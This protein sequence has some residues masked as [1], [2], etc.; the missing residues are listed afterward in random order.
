MSAGGGC[1][2]GSPGTRP[3]HP[4]TEGN[5]NWQYHLPCHHLASYTWGLSEGHTELEEEVT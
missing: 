1:L 4:H 5:S 2:C 3:T